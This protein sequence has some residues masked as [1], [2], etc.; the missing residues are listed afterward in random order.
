MSSGPRDFLP[1]DVELFA[2]APVP[3]IGT[4]G[5]AERE[6]TVAALIEVMSESG[7][8]W[9]PVSTEMVASWIKRQTE[10]RWGS[11]L[12]NPFVRFDPQGTVDAGWAEWTEPDPATGAR[13]IALTQV[14]LDALADKGWVR[15]RTQ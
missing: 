1:S 6:F 9:R 8:E 4:F 10:G 2:R 5:R 13:R 11:L 7:N 15:K 12:C 14:T 3:L